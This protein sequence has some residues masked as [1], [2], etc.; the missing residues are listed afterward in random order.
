MSHLNP[1]TNGDDEYV[2]HRR[3]AQVHS[4][5]RDKTEDAHQ[6][7]SPSN[8]DVLREDTFVK[9]QA[10]NLALHDIK[11]TGKVVSEGERPSYN[12]R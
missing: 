6:H 9:C 4:R 1:I 11:Q 10:V 3:E 2:S 12:D 7:S 8:V 5:A